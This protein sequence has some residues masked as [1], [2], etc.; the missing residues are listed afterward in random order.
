M[1][2][3]DHRHMPT[4]DE[5]QVTNPSG[6]VNSTPVSPAQATQ[7][8]GLD[9]DLGRSYRDK[10]EHSWT[11][12]DRSEAYLDSRPTGGVFNPAA[13][14]GDPDW[15]EPESD[16]EAAART[17]H[18]AAQPRDPQTSDWLQ[19]VAS[20]RRRLADERLEPAPAGAGQLAWEAAVNCALE[21]FGTREVTRTVT[22]GAR[23]ESLQQPRPVLMTARP[24]GTARPDGTGR[25]ACMR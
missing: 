5:L 4:E 11:S 3:T 19:R 22:A 10:P 7:P 23:H 14:F 21:A 15:R 9:E 24:I 13:E 16:A 8:T 17:A 1:P 18:L 6:Q 12:F 2:T 25:P 20:C